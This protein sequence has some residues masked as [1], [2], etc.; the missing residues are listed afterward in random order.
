MN[1]NGLAYECK[2]VLA[3]Q[4]CRQG[5]YDQSQL[6]LLIHLQKM[7]L[8]LCHDFGLIYEDKIKLYSYACGMDHFK[9]EGLKGE[10][11]IGEFYF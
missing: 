8:K 7:F 9:N 11:S 10:F 6:F 4:I 1:I 2:G 3:M 5:V